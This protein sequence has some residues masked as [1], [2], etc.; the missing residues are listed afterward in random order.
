MTKTAYRPFAAFSA[1]LLTV[2]LLAQ[3]YAVPAVAASPATLV[4]TELA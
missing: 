4:V 3:T 1:A 2:L